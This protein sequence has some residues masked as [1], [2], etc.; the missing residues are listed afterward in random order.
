MTE[1]LIQQLNELVAGKNST[2]SLMVIT[3]DLIAQRLESRKKN[4]EADVVPVCGKELTDQITDTIDDFA[5]EDDDSR[6]IRYAT[7]WIAGRRLA[8]QR[9][10]EN[11]DIY[12]EFLSV[13]AGELQLKENA[14]PETA[15]VAQMRL[16]N[17]KTDRATQNI[18]QATENLSSISLANRLDSSKYQMMSLKSSLGVTRGALVQ[19]KSENKDYNEM[20][21]NEQ[22]RLDKLVDTACELSRLLPVNAED[23]EEDTA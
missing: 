20:T 15:S 19:V 14:P 4:D 11:A 18:R 7:A 5:D 3:A 22:R 1:Q 21:W 8:R 10:E 13:L 9:R 6:Y 2:A 23:V 12:C 17:R 16:W